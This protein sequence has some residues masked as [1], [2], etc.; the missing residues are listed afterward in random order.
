MICPEASHI[1]VSLF[2]IRDGDFKT[3]ILSNR[4]ILQ[5]VI[6]EKRSDRVFPSSLHY[7]SDVSS[8]EQLLGW[9]LKHG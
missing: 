6:P 9:K 2:L 8:E 7:L 3:T 4:I 1:A 5:G